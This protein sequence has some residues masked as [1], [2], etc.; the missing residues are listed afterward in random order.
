M[1]TAPDRKQSELAAWLL[2]RIE[3]FLDRSDMP[4]DGCI[5]GWHVMKDRS[6]VTRLRDGGDITTSKLEA[7]TAFMQN[8]ADFN[9]TFARKYRLKPLNIKRR[10]FP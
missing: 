2:A 4:A 10:T 1:K 5:F 7:I 6:L 3:E 9:E 8:P